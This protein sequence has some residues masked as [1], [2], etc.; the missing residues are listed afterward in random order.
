MERMQLGTLRK[1]LDNRELGLSEKQL[2]KMAIDATS[3]LG[4]SSL[5]SFASSAS[6]CPVY[7]L[8]A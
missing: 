4:E 5:H 7:V 6:S 1:L 8:L 2:I 3:G